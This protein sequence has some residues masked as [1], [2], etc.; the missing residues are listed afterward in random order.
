MNFQPPSGCD[1]ALDILKPLGLPLRVKNGTEPPQASIQRPYSAQSAVTVASS[2]SQ[3]SKSTL[4]DPSQAKP[5]IAQASPVRYTPSSQNDPDV[6][7]K[8]ISYIQDPR[9]Q[10]PQPGSSNGS[11]VQYNPVSRPTSSST[12]LGLTDEKRMGPPALRRLLPSPTFSNQSAYLGGYENRPISAPEPPS[13]D[14][15]ADTV[16]FSQLLP[17]VRELPFPKKLSN[18]ASNA[19][20]A[21]ST[22]PPLDHQADKQVP[23][24]K[25]MRAPARSEPR[26]L[27]STSN[28]S[29]SAPKARAKRATAVKA[30]F[31]R[32]PLS[33]AP[34]K[35]QTAMPAF[36]NEEPSSSAP[37]RMN[38]T[39]EAL[40][41][42]VSKMSKNFTP[43]PSRNGTETSN[44][45]PLSAIDD[46][47]TNKRQA[48]IANQDFEPATAQQVSPP[49]NP[50][51]A[52]INP[53][54]ILDSLDGWIRKYH[55]LPV[56]VPVP[57]PP[58]IAKDQLAEYA[59]KSDEERAKIIDN[60]IC[61]CLR[62]EN[63]GKL[64]D[65]VEGHWKRICLGF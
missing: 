18:Q 4:L 49:S 63:F 52:N 15:L 21:S 46:N 26:V 54:E 35:D 47:E 16:S 59:S 44:K 61:E 28:V 24:P 51:L 62:D 48:T 37:P 32:A 9:A 38:S 64:V 40:E 7:S 56:P 45:R 2:H 30:G 50:V 3:E 29:S 6:F 8:P 60:M 43:P 22:G 27:R 57:K 31:S 20:P 5:T 34:P 25:K 39:L 19:T 13:S 14:F 12:G 36:Y 10:R 55:D 33:T 23:K 65:D 1:T 11:S 58:M 41:Q 42:T 53:A 17:P